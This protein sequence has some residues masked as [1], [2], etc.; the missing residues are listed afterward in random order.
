VKRITSLL[1]QVA[2]WWLSRYAPIYDRIERLDSI[3][4]PSGDWELRLEWRGSWRSKRWEITLCRYHPGVLGVG[5]HWSR[6]R[7]RRG[8]RRLVHA[9]GAYEEMLA[10]ARRLAGGERAAP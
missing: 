1:S 7:I 4:G 8:L 5:G 10:E 6:I 9:R 3:K 2:R